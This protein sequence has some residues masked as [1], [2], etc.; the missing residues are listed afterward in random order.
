L[1]AET[2]S[3]CGVGIIIML[4]NGAI[5]EALSQLGHRCTTNK[6][7]Y[8]AL[9]FGYQIL[10][11]MGVKYVEAYNDSLLVMQQVCKVCQCLNG[12]FNS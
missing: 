4:P 6:N 8:E 2:R 1:D 3:G 10:H 12:P 9:L 7:K 5:F 11:D